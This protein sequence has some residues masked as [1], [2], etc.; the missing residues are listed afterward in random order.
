MAQAN[1]NLDVFKKGVHFVH[2][3]RRPLVHPLLK[4]RPF[5]QQVAHGGIGG[6]HCQRVAN[7]GSGKEGQIRFRLRVV[8]VLPLTAIKGVHKRR[9]A[10]HNANRHP[11]ANNFAVGHDV[12]FNPPRL[13]DAPLVDAE[14]GDDFIQ[15]ESTAA[16]AGNLAQLAQ[17]FNGAVVRVAALYRLHQHRRQ[18]VGVLTNKIERFGHAII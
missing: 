4:L 16:V 7:K 10:S 9:L 13:L 8:A 1:G 17:K 11:A 5:G 12:G 14:P 6:G 2:K 3:C 18:F 15:N